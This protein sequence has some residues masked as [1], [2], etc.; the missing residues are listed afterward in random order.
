[1]RRI[2]ADLHVHT[3]F[4]PC[5]SADMTP[6]FVAAEAARRGLQMIAVCDHNT[7]AA[8]RAVTDAAGPVPAVVA[9]IEITSRDD[10]HVL[11]WFP[12]VE[13]AQAAAAGLDVDPALPA[14][15]T[16]HDLSAVVALIHREGGLAV[17]AHVDRP[18]FS[19]PGQLG[20]I[21]NDV[22][23]DAL[24]ISAAGAARGRAASFAALGL[25]LVCSSDAHFPEDVGAGFTFLEVETP[26]F[27]ELARALRHGEG[28]RCILA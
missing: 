16:R 20:F 13:A 24:E 28:R 7:A 23:F 4:S 3:S 21:P 1:M 11:G 18:A 9:G 6:A 19:V 14:A 17:A 26:C 25:P 15:A 10:A 27:E 5:A 12:S 8:T 2:T 22:P